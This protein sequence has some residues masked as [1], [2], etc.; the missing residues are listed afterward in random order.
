MSLTNL[1]EMQRQARVRRIAELEAL[2]QDVLNQVDGYPDDLIDP[3][4]VKR[5]KAALPQSVRTER[6]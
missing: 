2:L 1:E 4:W 3:A 5:A 6:L